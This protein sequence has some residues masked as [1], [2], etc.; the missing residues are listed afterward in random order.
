MTTKRV[1]ADG[2]DD[3]GGSGDGGGNGCK[4]QRWQ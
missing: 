2:D 3:D 1:T 4:Q